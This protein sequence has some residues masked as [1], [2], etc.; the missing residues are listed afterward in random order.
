MELATIDMPVEEAQS[1]FEE[2]R[3]AVRER[4]D[5]EDEAIMRGY[6]VLARGQQV[7][8]LSHTIRA[9][10]VEDKVFRGRWN[11][12]NTVTVTLPRLAVARANRTEVW[13]RGVDERGACTMQTKRDP[14]VNNRVDVVRFADET[15]EAGTTD[16]WGS[17]P[18]IKAVV[19][20]VPPR[21]RPRVGLGNFHVLFEAEWG[22]DPEPPVDPALLRHIGG[23][24]YAVVATWDLTELERAV[25]SGR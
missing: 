12:R 21:L 18:R 10:G 22:L 8:R 6:R 15:F 14:H 20:N 4:H 1:A 16:E 3:A 19:P 24:L 9:G 13:T 11:S 5:A 23:D 17:T 7:L 2:Y 25:L